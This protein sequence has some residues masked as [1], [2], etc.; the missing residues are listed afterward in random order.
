MLPACV[1]YGKALRSL[2]FTLTTYIR[3]HTDPL[4]AGKY[5]LNATRRLT[6]Q[7]RIANFLRGCMM[8]Y[9]VLCT[10][11]Y[12]WGWK[13]RLVCPMPINAFAPSCTCHTIMLRIDMRLRTPQTNGPVVNK[14]FEKALP[15]R[16][17]SWVFVPFIWWNSW[18]M[19][20][21]KTSLTIY[22]Q[23]IDNRLTIV[24][25][26]GFSVC[27]WPFNF[28]QTFSHAWF[29]GW[30]RGNLSGNSPYDIVHC[31]YRITV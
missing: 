27:S 10:T 14:N 23:Y 15:R 16:K 12:C 3:I 6:K 19:K 2:S 22:S 13:I 17:G 20:L 26:V 29:A 1:S 11:I 30:N 18:G 8:F 5:L 24:E 21:R 4:S 25:F 31:N 9:D 28:S 7:L